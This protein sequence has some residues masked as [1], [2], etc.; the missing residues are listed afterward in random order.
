M[1]KSLGVV[2]NIRIIQNSY[3]HTSSRECLFV[4]STCTIRNLSLVL[5]FPLFWD[6]EAC[7]VKG[8]KNVHR[9]LPPQNRQACS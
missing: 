1:S 3:R 6:N 9:F 2:K 4:F 5:L 8:L 7:I